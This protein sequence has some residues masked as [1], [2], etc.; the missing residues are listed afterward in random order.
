MPGCIEGSSSIEYLV[1]SGTV[2]IAGQDLA[3]LSVK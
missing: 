3:Q 1:T 2:T